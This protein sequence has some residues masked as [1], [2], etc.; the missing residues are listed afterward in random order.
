MKKNLIGSCA[1][2]L[3]VLEQHRDGVAAVGAPWLAGAGAG[4]GAVA[5]GWSPPVLP[6]EHL[7]S[8]QW[9]AKP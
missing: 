4:L 7:A 1:A 9:P 3:L 5:P 6:D 8:R 2:V